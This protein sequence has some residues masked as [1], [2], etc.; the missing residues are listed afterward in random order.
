M[1]PASPG[2]EGAI[3]H[4][5]RPKVYVAPEG[6][7]VAVS[8]APVSYWRKKAME[9]AEAE[10]DQEV[11]TC[12][13]L[14]VLADLDVNSKFDLGCL[15]TRPQERPRGGLRRACELLAQEGRGGCQG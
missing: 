11:G 15:E 7:P 10:A 4:G 5:T 1:T 6:A 14:P 13:G 9:A 3:G 8:T 2:V 12:L